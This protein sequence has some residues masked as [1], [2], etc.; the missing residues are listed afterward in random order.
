MAENDLTIPTQGSFHDVYSPPRT[1]MEGLASKPLDPLALEIEDDELVKIF[2]K[3][4]NE[5]RSFYRN[6]MDL[7]DRRSTNELY[8]FGRQIIE[9]DKAHLLKDYESRFHDNVLYEIEATL[10]PLAMSRLPDL[11]VTPGNDSEEA[12]LMSQE[13]SKVI[14]TQIKERENRQVLGMVS[15]HRDVY[16]TG[17]IKVRWDPE[18]DDYKFE[19]IHPDLIDVDY[20]STTNS[21]QDMEW[22]SQIVPTTI[23]EVLMR[24]PEGR[25]D[26]ISELQKNGIRPGVDHDWDSM[27]TRVKIREIWFSWYKKAPGQNKWE[28][29]EGVMW[30]YQNCIL[31]KMKNPNFD[32]EGE[33]R[34]YRY[35]DE[36]KKGELSID[37]SITIIATGLT[38]PDVHK[39]KV[40]HNYFRIPQKPYF[41]LGYDQWGKQPYDETTALEQ[42]LGNQKALDKR[43]KQIEET[44]DNRGH[45]IWSKESGLKA[46]DIQGMDMSDPG[47]DVVVN[48]DVNMVHKYIEPERPTPQEFKDIEDIRNRMYAVA[49]ANAVRG[50][51]QT[52]VAT[53]NQIARESDFTRADDVVEDTI[54]SAAEW[55]G[56]WS[57]H[58]IKLRY[59]KDHF[60]EVLGVAGDIVYVKL[61]R[62]M[63]REGMIV[64]IK[65]SGTDKLKAQNNAMDMAKMGMI[66]PVQFYRDMGLSDPE[67][68][69][70]QLMLWMVDKQGYMLQYIEGLDTSE[71]LASALVN[72]G[73]QAQQSGMQQPGMEQPQP[74]PGMAAAPQPPPSNMAVNNPSPQNTGAVPTNP[75]TAQ[76]IPNGSPRNM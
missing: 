31:K 53:T 5:S 64:K 68:R 37:E 63:V 7:Y 72:S 55:M 76:G 23:K 74:Q 65:A 30:K 32:Y 45:H 60:R 6:E 11:I 48:G 18:I 1:S 15:K 46:A 10:K 17:V 3:R 42:N 4:L 20:T 49:G 39:E 27:A 36:N 56:D 41:F 40:Y 26:F 51:I 8:Y 54:N 43:G 66:D 61:N 38:P 52:D 34:Y 16:F 21:A 75:A 9:K 57:L 73:I 59:T 28:C 62:N 50:Q 35:D 47:Q 25:D 24:F 69:A 13:L 71:S 29:I 44:L 2:D 14:D 19:A 12:K 22:I 70:K 67:G 33:E 58:F